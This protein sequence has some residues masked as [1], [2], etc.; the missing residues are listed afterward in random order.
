MLQLAG[1]DGRAGTRCPLLDFWRDACNAF[2]HD[3]E[4]EGHGVLLTLKNN[5]VALHLVQPEERSLDCAVCT[6]ELP[7]LP[8]WK[9]PW[10]DRI[11][12]R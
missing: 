8:L 7:P 5:R 11:F 2:D 6:M 12:G 3:E 1:G 4:E 10:V 9:Q